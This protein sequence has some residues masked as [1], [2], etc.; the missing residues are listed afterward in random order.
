MRLR[1]PRLLASASGTVC[2]YFWVVVIWAWPM[3]SIT[4]FR[5]DPPARSQE[6]WAW[7]RSRT[8]TSRSTPD[9]RTAGSQMRVRKCSVKSGAVVE[10]GQ[11]L[12][13]HSGAAVGSGEPVGEVLCRR[14]HW[15]SDCQHLLGIAAWKRM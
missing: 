14:R 7:R 8:W 10:P 12:A 13:V 9:A 5:S 11:D 4:D 3:R 2:R 1:A 6:A 15:K